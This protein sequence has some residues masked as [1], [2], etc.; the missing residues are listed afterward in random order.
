[1][2]T[3]SRLWPSSLKGQVLLA[4]ALALLLAQTLAAILQYQVQLERRRD[5][6][7]HMLAFRFVNVWRGNATAAVGNAAAGNATDAAFRALRPRPEPGFAPQPQDRR[8]PTSENELRRILAELG[9]TVADVAVLERPAARDAVALE[10]LSARAALLP[11]DPGQATP[12]RILVAAV[13]QRPGG[14][15]L[16][17]RALTPPNAPYQLAVLV[18]QTLIIY[19]VLVSVMALV[20]RRITQPLA[21]LTG[22]LE[23]F[24]SDR[25][26]EGQLQPEGPDDLRRLIAAHNAME[27]RIAALLDEKDVML[28]AIGHDLKT[29]LAALRVR[30]ESVTDDAERARMAEIIED[31]ARSLDDMLS[32]ARVGRPTDRLE[33]TELSALVAAVVEEF[34]DMGEPVEL[35]DTSRV[36][37][38]L[39]P[40]WLRRGLRNLIANAVRYGGNARISVAREGDLAVVRVEDDGPGLPE[41]DLDRMFQ[42]FTRGEPSRNS[43]TGGAGLGLTLARAVADQHGGTLTL[44]NRLDPGGAITGLT[45]TLSLPLA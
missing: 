41:A 5:S 25:T 1:M 22:R 14:V 26:V 23:R 15:W 11:R 19:A 32:L 30:I 2:T 44:A 24:A 18:T 10:A 21:A 27:S 37:L 20:V 38:R 4:L 12:E 9:I 28:G 33:A 42:P 7:T 45:A 43:G 35:A 29:P 40:T 17:A 16:V 36:V 34:E 39:R 6:Q 8:L 31:L 3:R 13:R